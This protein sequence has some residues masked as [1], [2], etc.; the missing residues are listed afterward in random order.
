MQS[1]AENIR[2][3]PNATFT[4]SAEGEQR[5]NQYTLQKILGSG[6]FGVVHLAKDND[7]NR[8]VAIKEISKSK[9]R[10]T[11]AAKSIG[12]SGMLGGLR[13]RLAARG[14]AGIA[15]SPSKRSEN[16]S[17]IDSQSSAE[18]AIDLVREEIAILKK[19]SH[20]HIVKLFEVLDDPQGDSLYMVYELC[21]KG[22]IMDINLNKTCKSFSEAECRNI[23]HQIL[24]GIEYCTFPHFFILFFLSILFFF[25]F[26]FDNISN[27]PLLIS[28]FSI[29]FWIRSDMI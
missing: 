5:L 20:P 4:E 28:I 3:T 18:S 9:L 25:S 11:K 21:E 7:L 13:G 17:S 14:R 6:S 16:I 12:P 1:Q 10:K 19:L 15:L 27:Y 24:L 23:F 8:M 2:E 26:R 29:S 22:H